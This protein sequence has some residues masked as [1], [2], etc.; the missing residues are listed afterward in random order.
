[1]SQYRT[2]CG[3]LSGGDDIS[4]RQSL[5]MVHDAC[6]I[7]AVGVETGQPAAQRHL[8]RRTLRHLVGQHEVE[9][10]QHRPVQNLR[11]IGGGDDDRWSGVFIQELQERVQDTT[12]LTD[13]VL[14]ASGCGERVDLVEQIHTPRRAD[15]IK[16]HAQLLGGLAHE[17]CDQPMQ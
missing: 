15:C 6:P 13:I 17:F 1:M 9:A 7:D 3:V 10:A 16:D 11:K 5:G 2:S 4:G 14:G 12:C 8:D